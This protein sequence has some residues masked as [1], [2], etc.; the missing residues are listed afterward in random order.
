MDGHRTDGR[1]DGRSKVNL[2]SVQSIGQ[3]TSRA[4]IFSMHWCMA[5]KRHFSMKFSIMST[6]RTNYA[7]FIR[8]SWV[9]AVCCLMRSV[10]ISNALCTIAC[11][12][13]ECVQISEQTDML[14]R[15]SHHTSRGRS[16]GQLS[17][18][19]SKGHSWKTDADPPDIHIDPLRPGV[20]C[21]LMLHGLRLRRRSHGC[22]WSHDDQSVDAHCHVLHED[23]KHECDAHALCSASWSRHLSL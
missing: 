11:V 17:Q 21:G 15:L 12:I 22:C 16:C 23:H 1:I 9:L 4:L 10:A 13:K 5:N 6:K 3:T 18:W 20:E 8:F 7:L 14:G 19:H 2:Y